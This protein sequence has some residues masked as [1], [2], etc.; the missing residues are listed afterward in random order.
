MMTGVRK[1][2]VWAALLALVLT[3]AIACES[4]EPAATGPSATEIENIVKAAVAGG[5]QLTASDVQ[6]IVNDSAG[7]LTAADVRKIVSDSAVTQLTASDVQR[8]VNDSAGTQLTASDVQRIVDA[9]AGGQLTA[10]DVRKIVSDSVVGQLTA[11]DVQKIVDA[12]TSGQLSAGDVQ[13]IVQASTGEQLTAGDVEKIVDASAMG[14]LTTADVQKIISESVSEAVEEAKKATA[15]AEAAGDAA[16]A[17]GN[18][19]MSAG[20][21]AEAAAMDAKKALAG[22]ELQRELVAAVTAPAPLEFNEAPELAQLVL[23]GKLPPVEERLPSSPL[24]IPVFDEIG[25]YGGDMRS[26]WTSRSVCNLERSARSALFRFNTDG[27]AIIPNLAQ[28]LDI[29]P[30]GLVTTVKLRPGTKW[31]DGAPFTADD[32]IFWLDDYENNDE[33]R[34]GRISGALRGLSEAD[35]GTIVKVDDNTLQY[36]YPAPMT[37]MAKRLTAVCGNYTFTPSH[38]MKQF[39][40]AYNENAEADAKAAGY[41][42]WVQL[43]GARDYPHENPDIPVLNPWYPTGSVLKDDV[44]VFKRNPYYVGVDAE[45]NQLPYIDT[46]TH[47][48]LP[49]DQERLNLMLL[50]GELDFQA[51]GINNADVPL[52]KEGEER[53][54]YRLLGHPVARGI[55]DGMYVNHSLQGK[56]GDLLRNVDFRRAL[57]VAIDRDAINQ[58]TYLGL[59]EARQIVPLKNSPFYPGDEA[60]FAWTQYDVDLA[61]MMLDEIVPDKDSEGF[62]TFPDGERLVLRLDAW[63]QINHNASLQVPQYWDAVGLKTEYSGSTGGEQGGN[64]VRERVHSNEFQFL[65]YVVNAAHPFV[66][67]RYTAPTHYRSFVA[68][69]Y[70]SYYCQCNPSGWEGLE[71][72]KELKEL[73]DL[74]LKGTTVPESEQAAL[75]KEI[76]RR[77]GEDVYG[78]GLIGNVPRYGA[79]KNG[80]R[81]VPTSWMG[82]AAERSPSTAFPEQFY[83]AR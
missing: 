11:S 73:L 70:G 80:L 14:Q 10:A 37:S 47:F 83:W 75:G 66:Q 57:S 36:V 1:V 45:G 34:P 9:S 38:Y 26:A 46:I 82:G 56:Y 28:S 16:K 59:G 63:N 48:H 20:T 24:V 15:A 19:A 79:I 50:G 18:A 17:A 76:F 43:Y 74:H 42:S 25:K 49:G 39:H 12:S 8:I 6:R 23:G 51:Q 67:A 72:H 68:P 41:D 13:R 55:W 33:I 64:I 3:G 65:M 2:L 32:F 78:I 35:D 69:G 54:G 61:N 71:P 31:S 40:K 30:D 27:S 58:N 22:V 29:S 60:A 53:G 81:N 77:F 7:Q 5:D 21:A 44:V 52:L 62:R 4:D